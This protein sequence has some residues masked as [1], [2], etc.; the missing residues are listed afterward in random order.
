MCIGATSY[1]DRQKKALLAREKKKKQAIKREQNKA[2]QAENAARK[3]ER[4]AWLKT[5]RQKVGEG[6]WWGLA[7][8][9]WPIQWWKDKKAWKKEEAKRAREHD[10]DH[11]LTVL[12][13]SGP[14]EP[15]QEQGAQ[16]SGIASGGPVAKS[17]H[18][19]K[20]RGGS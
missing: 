4:D 9:T 5:H 3:S 10:P 12:T 2:K 16:T 8:L 18:L 19:R 15:V 11:E 14:T 13:S 7:W 17:G 1:E 20:R 6:S